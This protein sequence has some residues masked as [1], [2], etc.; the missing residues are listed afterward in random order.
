MAPLDAKLMSSE[1]M[2]S[3]DEAPGAAPTHSRLFVLA[4][5]LAERIDVRLLPERPRSTGPHLLRLHVGGDVVDVVVMRYGAAVAF[6]KTADA[7][8]MALRRMTP[9]LIRPLEHRAEE[10]LQLRVDGD[11]DPNA[12]WVL[13]DDILYTGPLDNTHLQLLGLM[14][15][16]SVV[17]DV[18]EDHLKATFDVV[19]P[20]SRELSISGRVR[21]GDRRLMQQLGRSLVHEQRMTGRVELREKPDLLWENPSLE[22]IH[23]RLADDLEL[24]ERD[25]A[26]ERKLELVHRTVKSL[27][28]LSLE[29]R[30]Y[31]AEVAIVLLIVFEVFLTLFG[32]WTKTHG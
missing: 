16:R 13:D 31:R 9:A 22:R 29:H 21:P 20:W 30:T 11:K 12:P 23:H 28:T 6:A 5:A 7:A 25:E 2:S 14:L 26:I 3:S 19:E 1:L 10:S 32:M 4:Q 18:Y 24:L 8:R 27:H 17:L 15:A